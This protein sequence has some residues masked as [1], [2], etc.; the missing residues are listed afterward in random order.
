MRLA[1]RATSKRRIAHG[2]RRKTGGS[3][4][5]YWISPDGYGEFG[6]AVD[7]TIYLIQPESAS[8]VAGM[9]LRIIT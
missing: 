6:V 1:A 5:F 8:H 3:S 4:G 9:V 2:E 7:L